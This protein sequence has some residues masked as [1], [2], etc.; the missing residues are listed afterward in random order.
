M[1]QNTF[2]CYM[3]TAMNMVSVLAFK[4]LTIPFVF[5]LSFVPKS[6]WLNPYLTI[7]YH[8]LNPGFQY[9]PLC[10]LLDGMWGHIRSSLYDW[11]WK[12]LSESCA[13]MLLKF[14]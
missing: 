1:I 7:R 12:S 9:T 13:N 14:I 5:F 4:K 10:L 2:A 8:L 3:P 11:R 6:K